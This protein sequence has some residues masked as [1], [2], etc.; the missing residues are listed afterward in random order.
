MAVNRFF[1]PPSYATVDEQQLLESLIVESIQVFGMDV[2]YIPRV[3]NDDP[4]YLE[5]RLVRFEEAI[6]LEMYLKSFDGFQGDGHFMSNLGVEIRDAVTFSVAN[7]RF[8]QEVGT[9]RGFT[10]PREGDLIYY[11][12][13]NSCFEI[14]FV[15]KF[16]VHYPL[17]KL[18]TYD[19]RCELFEYSGQTFATGNPL[20]DSVMGIM[21]QDMI[22]RSIQTEDG[23]ALK[24]EDGF[25]ILPEDYDEEVVDPLDDALDLQV[26]ADTII[27]WSENDIFSEGRF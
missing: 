9:A 14:K 13:S 8:M 11:P 6:P 21:S 5:D 22:F 24:T 23:M 16:T 20:I 2:V 25:F 3:G 26:E 4:V 18:Y 1:H 15:D 10:R 27:D 12:F 17:G 7:L 19:V